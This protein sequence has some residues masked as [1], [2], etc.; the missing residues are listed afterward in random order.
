LQ[1]HLRLAAVAAAAGAPAQEPARMRVAVV[2][3]A[4]VAEEEEVVAGVA[5]L[6]L[7]QLLPQLRGLPPAPILPPRNPPPQSTPQIIP[8]AIR[9]STQTQ[10]ANASA[11]ITTVTAAPLVG[12]SVTYGAQPGTYNDVVGTFTATDPNAAPEDYLATIDWGDGE[13]STGLV[14]GSN[15]LFA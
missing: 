4:V 10:A 9:T 7:G 8:H 12:Q 2:A 13:T 15:G 5:G 3:A 11:G 6:H 14:T 1:K